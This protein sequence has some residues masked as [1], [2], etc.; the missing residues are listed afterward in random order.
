MVRMVGPYVLFFPPISERL[1]QQ[2]PLAVQLVNMLGWWRTA[3]ARQRQE[4]AGLQG[5]AVARTLLS[6]PQLLIW[7]YQVMKQVLNTFNV[8]SSTLLFVFSVGVGEPFE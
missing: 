2:A 1:A 3:M 5:L 6:M 7:L 8:F 4:A